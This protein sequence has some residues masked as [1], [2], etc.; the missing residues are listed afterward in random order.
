[1]APL[2]FVEL[3][4]AKAATVPVAVSFEVALVSGRTV[5]VPSG[6]DAVELAR[7]VAVLEARR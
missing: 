4:A 7:L 2:R 5:R 1:V 3:A 6:F